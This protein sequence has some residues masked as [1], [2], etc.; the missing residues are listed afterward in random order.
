MVFEMMEG[1]VLKCVFLFILHRQLPI[2]LADGEAFGKGESMLSFDC[3]RRH[4]DDVS[5]EATEEVRLHQLNGQTKS[6]T[7]AEV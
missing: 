2:T 5:K 7:E 3:W 4:D 6:E 1:G